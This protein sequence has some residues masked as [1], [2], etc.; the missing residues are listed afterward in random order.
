MDLE[1]YNRCIMCTYSQDIWCKSC[2][3]YKLLKGNI[4]HTFLVDTSYYVDKSLYFSTNN[5]KVV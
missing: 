2:G 4:K 3:L 5:F 1:L